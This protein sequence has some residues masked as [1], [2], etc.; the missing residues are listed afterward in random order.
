VL[1]IVVVIVVI[2]VVVV[3]VV[4]IVVVVVVIELGYAGFA[5]G[6]ERVGVLRLA[7]A[8]EFAGVVVVLRKWVSVIHGEAA[9]L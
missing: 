6:E 4:V 3:V 9:G 5:G 2:V 8:I 1:T 7:D